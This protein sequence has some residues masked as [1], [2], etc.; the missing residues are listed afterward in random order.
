MSDEEFDSEHCPA[1][2]MLNGEP[3]VD[4][5][6]CQCWWDGDGCC[7]CGAVAMSDDEKRLQGMI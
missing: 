3:N 7:R 5:S 6:H 1:E 4:H 2:K